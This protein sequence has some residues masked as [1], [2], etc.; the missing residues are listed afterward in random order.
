MKDL[1]KNKPQFKP[2][3]QDK[4]K[5][6][7]PRNPLDEGIVEETD[8]EIEEK[9]LADNALE[10][11]KGKEGEDPRT[12][13]ALVNKPKVDLQNP[14]GYDPDLPMNKQREFNGLV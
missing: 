6:G 3:L 9:E 8:K 5:A 7:V 12:P 4:A 10:E 14:V 1:R 13:P 2:R 11:L